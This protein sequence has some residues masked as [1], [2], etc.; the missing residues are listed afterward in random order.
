M[1]VVVVQFGNLS[2]IT[3]PGFDGRSMRFPFSLVEAQYIG[4]PQQSFQTKSGRVT[5]ET[6]GTLLAVWGINDQG[7]PKVLFQ[8][9]KEHL[10]SELRAG[11]SP[12]RM[13]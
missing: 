10:L 2:D 6:S 4:T 13:C 7:L 9:A 8:I 5:V 1:T 3:T 12:S 11:S